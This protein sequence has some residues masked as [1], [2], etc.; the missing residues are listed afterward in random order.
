M[1]ERAFRHFKP[2]LL[3]S[4]G[5]RIGTPWLRSTALPRNDYAVSRVISAASRVPAIADV[6][7]LRDVA[8]TCHRA[9]RFVLS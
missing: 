4:S 3:D 6:D 2:R 5:R 1:V 7:I 8:I 9:Q